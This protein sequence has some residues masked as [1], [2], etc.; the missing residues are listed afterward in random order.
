M[1]MEAGNGHG[2]CCTKLKRCPPGKAASN[3]EQCKAKESAGMRGH[4]RAHTRTHARTH[5]HTHTHTTHTHT[6]T[7]T[8]TERERE[9]EREKVAAT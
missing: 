2:L 4:T 6:H 9:R 7:H 5:T 1:C 8:H 3:T